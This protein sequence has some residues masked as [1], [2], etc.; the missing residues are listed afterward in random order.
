MNRISARTASLLSVLSLAVV[1]TAFSQTVSAAEA[2]S[3][4]Q[5]N[6]LAATAKTP[7]EH[8]RIADYY[9][10]QAQNYLAQAA[11]HTAMIAAY[12]ASPSTK[13]QASEVTHC[14]NLVTS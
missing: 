8:Q 14:A 6:T 10:A 3:K 4:T 5:L 7:A 2:L 9:Q 13:H 11:D 12:K 1:M